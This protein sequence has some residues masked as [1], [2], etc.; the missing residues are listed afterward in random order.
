[1]QST[2][3]DSDTHSVWRQLAPLLEEAMTRLSEKDRTLLALRFFENKS[4]AET[5]AILGIQEWAAH[6]RVNRAV[7]KLRMFFARRGVVLPV[8]ALTAAISAN[9]VQA[10]PVGLAV[11]ISTAAALAG[12][13]I[14]T[15]AFSCLFT[16]GRATRFSPSSAWRGA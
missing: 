15:S 13:T 8:A 1:M 6:K 11:T 2:L 7:E 12:T 16:A 10:A 3:N 14:S 4:G 9:A 5:A